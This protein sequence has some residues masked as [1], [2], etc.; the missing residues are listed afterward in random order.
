MRLNV[1][2][3]RRQHH[4]HVAIQVWVDVFFDGKKVAV[5]CT[6][7]DE[8]LG[9]VEVVDIPVQPRFTQ[10]G[11]KIKTNAWHGKVEIRMPDNVPDEIKR[12][13]EEARGKERLRRS[14]VHA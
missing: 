5:G 3:Q 6:M 12:C 9:V 2:H 8:E 4:L 10:H 14:G 11:T 7:A 13:Y 1:F